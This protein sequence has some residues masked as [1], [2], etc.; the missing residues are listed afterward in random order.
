MEVLAKERLVLM[1]NYEYKCNACGTSEDHYRHVDKRDET[2][3][4]QY[5]TK[6]TIRVIN[7]VPFKLNGA[8]F[9][10]TGG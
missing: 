6:P 8:G 3:S 1:P 9:Y 10:S 4:C 7:A 5:C 2:P